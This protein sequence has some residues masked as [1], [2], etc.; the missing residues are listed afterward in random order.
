ME[1]SVRKYTEEFNAE[2]VNLAISMVN[3][4]QAAK[5]LG[6]PEPTL[7]TWVKKVRESGNQILTTPDGDTKKINVG[8]V[9]D[10]NKK[11]KKQLLRLEQEKAILKKA[12][13]YFAKE[14]G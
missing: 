2:A 1:K 12:A 3:V 6:I 14:L 11:L 5:D 10:E 13:T 9:L 8:K 4:N 7:H